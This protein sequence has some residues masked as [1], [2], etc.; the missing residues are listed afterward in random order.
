MISSEERLARVK[1]SERVLL[2][3][4][5]LRRSETC[6]A[7]YNKQGLQCVACNPDCP[8]NR[9]RSAA[10]RQGYKGV[11]IAPGG[12]LALKYIKEIMPEGVVAVACHKELQEGI[13]AVAEHFKQNGT[14]PVMVAVPLTKDG[15]VDTEVDEER[16]LGAIVLG[17]S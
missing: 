9:L 12:S 15:C 16:A 5:C 17:C 13:D 1:P 8:V 11:C 7:K 3:S 10:I 6:Q 4:H 14:G 2:I